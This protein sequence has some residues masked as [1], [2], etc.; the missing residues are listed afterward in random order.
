MQVSKPMTITIA[1]SQGTANSHWIM[2]IFSRCGKVFIDAIHHRND[3]ADIWGTAQKEKGA[4]LEYLK[5][6]LN[7][8]L[9][10]GEKFKYM[11]SRY[12]EASLQSPTPWHPVWDFASSYHGYQWWYWSLA[13]NQWQSQPCRMSSS[14]MSKHPRV[15]FKH[16][17]W[18]PPMSYT[19][20]GGW[21]W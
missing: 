14:S 18:V 2:H 19:I 1:N 9:M 20:R 21:W 13:S 4:M 7:R 8:N 6:R 10:R 15:S 5:K 11:P 3:A 17:G 12:H 16:G